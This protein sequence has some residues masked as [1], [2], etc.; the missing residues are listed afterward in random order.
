MDK[1]ETPRRSS[2]LGDPE[3]KAVA[4]KTNTHLALRLSTMLLAPITPATAADMPNMEQPAMPALE[5]PERQSLFAGFYIGGRQG[6][7]FSD[8]TSFATDGGSTGF[9]TE[10][11]FGRQFGAVAGYSFGPLF[12]PVSPRFEIEGSYG[13]FSVDEHTV[14]GLVVGSTDSFGDLTQITGLANV[15]LDF[16]LG[17]TGFGSEF[18]SRLTPFIGVG[19]GYS[20]VELSR[21]GVSATGVVIDGRD[22]GMTWQVSAG[23]SYLIW[24]KTQIELGYRHMRTEDLE[25]TS[26][27]GTVSSTDVI[28]NLVTLGLRRSF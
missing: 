14:N 5:Q 9:Q 12:G 13:E 10:Y 26:E 3:A 22:A 4:M 6:L 8:G 28:N 27:D 19:V 17:Q 16:N 18:M 21:Q 25:F 24:E 11:S 7:S 15:F 1:G 20:E 2:I 23:V